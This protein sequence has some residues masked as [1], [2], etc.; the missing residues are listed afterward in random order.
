MNLRSVAKSFGRLLG[1]AFLLLGVIGGKPEAIVQAF[2]RT[3]S[4]AQYIVP[5]CSAMGFAHVLRYTG[6]DQHLVHLLVKPLQK[7]QFIRKFFA[8]GFLPVGDID[9]GDPYRLP[10]Q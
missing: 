5:I 8:P 7:S 6:C 10:R 9:G 1:L 3:F 4:S 2:F